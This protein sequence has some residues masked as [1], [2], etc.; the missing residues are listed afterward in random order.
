MYMFLLLCVKLL[1]VCNGRDRNKFLFQTAVK[2]SGKIAATVYFVVRCCTSNDCDVELL[3]ASDG[4]ALVAD[5][6]LGKSTVFIQSP[7]VCSSV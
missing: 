4:Y 6:H 7:S 2:E 5:C 3:K 1:Y